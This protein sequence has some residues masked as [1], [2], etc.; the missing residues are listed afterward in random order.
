VWLETSGFP[1]GEGKWTH[2]PQAGNRERGGT[3]RRASSRQYPP[4]WVPQ[5]AKRPHAAF[6]RNRNFCDFEPPGRRGQKSRRPGPY[7]L[8]KLRLYQ[9]NIC[10]SYISNCSPVARAIRIFKPHTP[11]VRVTGPALGD[12]KVVSNPRDILVDNISLRARP[13]L[14]CTL[15][16]CEGKGWSPGSSREPRLPKRETRSSAQVSWQHL[17]RKS[18]IVSSILTRSMARLAGS[19]RRDISQL[20]VFFSYLFSHISVATLFERANKIV[21]M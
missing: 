13:C 18:S 14:T 8:R 16:K 19:T 2:S 9:Y 3:E 20:V 7:G 6:A 12:T 21:I 15:P 11:G 1:P 4:E 10:I 17:V 5:R